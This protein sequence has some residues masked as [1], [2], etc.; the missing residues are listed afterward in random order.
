MDLTSYPIPYFTFNSCVILQT[1]S[2][3]SCAEWNLCD[4]D[5]PK[6]RRKRILVQVNVDCQVLLLCSRI[7]RKNVVKYWNL[8]WR[9]VKNFTLIKVRSEHTTHH[10]DRCSDRKDW[11]AKCHPPTRKCRYRSDQYSD[12]ADSD[13]WNERERDFCVLIRKMLWTELNETRSFIKLQKSHVVWEWWRISTQ[14]S[15]EL[16]WCARLSIITRVKWRKSSRIW[17]ISSLTVLIFSIHLSDS[18]FISAG[19]LGDTKYVMLLCISSPH[20]ASTENWK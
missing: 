19:N 18:C 6:S 16:T 2:W 1:S 4:F 11:M 20:V 13:K 9:W 12:L 5:F 15:T 14:L 17:P 3:C 10:A 7:W 8:T